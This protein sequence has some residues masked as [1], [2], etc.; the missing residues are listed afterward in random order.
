M[1]KI[2]LMRSSHLNCHPIR[3]FHTSAC[4]TENWATTNRVEKSS[5]LGSVIKGALPAR[6]GMGQSAENACRA[7]EEIDLGLGAVRFKLN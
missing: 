2:K 5:T 6:P 4:V 3:Q 7:E 1:H